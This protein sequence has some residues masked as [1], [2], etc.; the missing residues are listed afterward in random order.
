MRVIYI[1]PQPRFNEKRQLEITKPEATDKVYI[2]GRGAETLDAAAKACRNGHALVCAR[3]FRPLGNNP[4]QINAGLAIIK[5]RGRAIEDAET[6][7]RSDKDGAWMF[8]MTLK[9][10]HSEK[11]LGDN[12]S[13]I[14][15]RG[16]IVRGQR[17]AEKR[18]A[19][20]LAKPIWTSL[21][22]STNR[23]AVA[24]MPGWTPET[25]NKHLGP[26]GRPVGRRKKSK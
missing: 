2:E 6:G 26:S 9:Q 18:M 10:I 22:Y 21:K 5:K 20:K 23:E 14:G 13:E 3:W 17:L 7:D 8:S 19:K 11:S 25:A 16:G 15:E 12:A 1:C 24:H 4:A